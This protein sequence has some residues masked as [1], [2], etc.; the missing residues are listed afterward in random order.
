MSYALIVR[1]GDR[2][3]CIVLNADPKNADLTVQL[4]TFN[5]PI[6]DPGTCPGTATGGSCDQQVVFS[7]GVDHLVNCVVTTTTKNVRTSFMNVTTG[8]NA[9]AK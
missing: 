1:S 8:N 2:A 7:D 6:F 9:E 5:V 4:F 3:A